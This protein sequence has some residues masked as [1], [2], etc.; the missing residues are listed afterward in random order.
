MDRRS[1]RWPLSNKN[2]CGRFFA[3]V[4]CMVVL[5]GYWS[6]IPS[7]QEEA[8]AYPRLQNGSILPQ[9]MM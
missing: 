3:G 4:V 5:Q 7:A 2:A 9:M 8:A 6:L 1:G